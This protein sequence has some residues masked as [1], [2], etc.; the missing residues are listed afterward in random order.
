MKKSKFADTFIIYNNLF[1]VIKH[2]IFIKYVCQFKTVVAP[3]N[4]TSCQ[5][6]KRQGKTVKVVLYECSTSTV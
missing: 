2:K 3:F 1:F 6:V 5:K 4:T